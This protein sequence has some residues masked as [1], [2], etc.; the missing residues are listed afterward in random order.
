MT[1]NCLSGRRIVAVESLHVGLPSVSTRE[2]RGRASGPWFPQVSRHMQ[3]AGYFFL[4]RILLCLFVPLV[5]IR[6]FVH[7]SFPHLRPRNKRRRAALWTPDLL[8]GQFRLEFELRAAARTS[9][10]HGR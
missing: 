10:H 7:G 1:R 6:C 3:C 4:P 5:S 2:T 9:D 8:A